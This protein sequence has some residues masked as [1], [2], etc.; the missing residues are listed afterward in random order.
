M[1]AVVSY[2]IGCILLQI[3]VDSRFD[4]KIHDSTYVNKLPSSG[5]RR[6]GVIV[7]IHSREM[8]GAMEKLRHWSAKCS[9][10][11]ANN[12]DLVLYST[13]AFPNDLEFTLK[14]V[15]DATPCFGTPKMVSANLPQQVCTVY[16]VRFIVCGV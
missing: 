11:I 14:Q 12:I 6:L 8:A 3:W 15:E 1:I 9:E 16:S 13:K 4:L 7:P 2:C 5:G 10:S